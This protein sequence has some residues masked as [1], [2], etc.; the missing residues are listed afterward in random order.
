MGEILQTKR[1][2]DLLPSSGQNFDI[3]FDIDIE[4]QHRNDIVS[5]LVHNVEFVLHFA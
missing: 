5:M 1:R 4:C 3:E 2:E